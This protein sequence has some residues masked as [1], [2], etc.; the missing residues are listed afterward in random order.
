MLLAI[1]ARDFSYDTLVAKYRKCLDNKSSVEKCEEMLGKWVKILEGNLQESMAKTQ[2]ANLKLEKD[3]WEK[4][5][6]ILRKNLELEKH[7][8]EAAEKQVH[9]YFCTVTSSNR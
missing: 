9:F 2:E 7:K 4:E 1:N 3:E 8:T 5:M 6:E